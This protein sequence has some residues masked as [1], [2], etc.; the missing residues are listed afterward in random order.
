MGEAID[1]LLDNALSYR[2][3]ARDFSRQQHAR[4]PAANGRAVRCA[5]RARGSASDVRRRVAAPP[6]IQLLLAAGSTYRDHAISAEASKIVFDAVFTSFRAVLEFFFQIRD[7]TTLNRHGNDRG[8]SYRSTIFLHRRRAED[9]CR[10]RD[11][12]PRGFRALA[13][14]DRDRPVFDTRLLGDRTGP[15]GPSRAQSQRINVPLHLPEVEAA[16]AYACCRE[17]VCWRVGIG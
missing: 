6:R 2:K 10:G 14:Q 4:K 7:P 3:L 15:S 9:C 13:E 17:R 11:C 12:R 5:S 1:H 8:V 16:A